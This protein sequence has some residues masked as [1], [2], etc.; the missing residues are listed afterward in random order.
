MRV[1]QHAMDLQD[2]TRLGMTA[3]DQMTAQTPTHTRAALTLSI[4]LSLATLAALAVLHWASPQFDP[5]WRMVSEYANG[6]SAWLLALMFSCWAASSFFLAYGLLPHATRLSTK[7]GIAFLVVA[8]IGEAMGGAFDI[9]HPWHMHAAILGMNGLPIAAL[10]IGIS[11]AR[12]GLWGTSRRLMLWLSNLPWISIV[13]MAIAMVLFFSSLSRAG[14]AIGPDSKPL[15]HLPPGVVA[16]G[17]WA[18]RLLIAAFCAWA[19]GAAWC[20]VPRQLRSVT[21]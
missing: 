1:K 16:Y 3:A 8:G 17:G 21:R 9:N 4:A 11:L 18:N 6:N 15:A 7:I 2:M 14:V 5:S 20:A 10:L 12:S 13:L 19:I